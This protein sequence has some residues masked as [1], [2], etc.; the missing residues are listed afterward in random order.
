[1]QETSFDAFDQRRRSL[2]EAFFKARDQQLLAKLQNEVAAFEAEKQLAH[3]SGIVE[4]SVLNHLVQAGIKAETLAA[5]GLV[6]L[7]EVAWCDGL[8]AAQERDAVLNAAAARGIEPDSAAHDLLKHW[9]D[10]RPDP[11]VFT[12]W[13]EYVHEMSRIM[14]KEALAGMR[15]QL[16]DR[17][18][19]VA[20]AAGGFL[21][22]STISKHERAKLEELSKAWEA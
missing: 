4:A 17:A 21:G 22:L 1:M 14:P 19:R 2:E 6:P 8:V 9:L 12:A 15:K 11:H 10:E 7:V 3:V 18:E 16:M 5:V 13:K 20:A